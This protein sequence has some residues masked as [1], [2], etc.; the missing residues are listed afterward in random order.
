MKNKPIILLVGI[1]II[2]IIGL[3][4]SKYFFNTTTQ[5]TL[6]F[7]SNDQRYNLQKDTRNYT[8]TISL[9]LEAKEAN[10]GYGKEIVEMYTYN[11][12]V[13]G[14]II[15]A[16]RG[17]TL[18]ITL[19]NSLDEPT[20]IHWHGIKVPNE[21][22]GVPYVTQEPVQPGKNHTYPFTLNQT[23]TY[24]YHSHFNTPEQVGKG[25]YGI[26]LIEDMN[27]SINYT[28]NTLLVLDDIRLSGNDIMPFGN[29][30]DM[31]M[32]GRYGNNFFINGKNNFE[33]TAHQN[34][35][36]KLN[37]VNTANA[38]IFQIG[39]EDTKMLIL[40]KDINAVEKPYEVNS[41]VLAPGE[42]AEVLVNLNSIDKEELKIYDYNSQIGNII[43]NIVVNSTEKED[44]TSYYTSLIEH[45][46]TQNIPDWSDKINQAPNATFNLYHFIK[47]GEF[48]WTINGKVYPEDPESI[49][50]EEGKFYKFR[51]INTRNMV[52]PM[53]THGQEFIILQ[54]NGVPQELNEFKDTLLVNPGETVDIGFIAQGKGTWVNHCHILEHAEA[55]MLME[56]HIT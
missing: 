26:L 50:L 8:K 4:S 29:P 37:L 27:Q 36:L 15:R 20:S 7:S 46:R 31:M 34:E 3:L 6:L 10:V 40:K 32:A 13:P 45:S 21:M 43:G 16:K 52:H 39:I 1:V 51:Y 35:L 55:G 12:Q 47:E 53:H 56:V 28:K 9:T 48:R 17:D 19:Q 41:L 24:W 30:H 22:D 49:T 44:K 2:L 42:R 5:E 54:R 23:G 25:L 18:N 33:I 38:R 14:P 11:N